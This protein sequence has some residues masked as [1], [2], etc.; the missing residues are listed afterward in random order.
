MVKY[1]VKIEDDLTIYS[2]YSEGIEA[3]DEACLK[4]GARDLR[5]GW[6]SVKDGM[7]LNDFHEILKVD[8]L[9]W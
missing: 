8:G 9:N 4:P 3:Y 2:T 7:P 1:Y 5:F 6:V